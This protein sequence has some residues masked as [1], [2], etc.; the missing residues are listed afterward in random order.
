MNTIRSFVRHVLEEHNVLNRLIIQEGGEGSGGQ[1]LPSGLEQSLGYPVFEVSEEYRSKSAV[2]TTT[3]QKNKSQIISNVEDMFDKIPQPGMN[4]TNEDEFKRA[5]AILKLLNDD[6][7]LMNTPGIEFPYN[8]ALFIIGW[9]NEQQSPLDTLAQISYNA[10][11]IMTKI[12]NIAEK[13]D[14]R[15]RGLSSRSRE[16]LGMPPGDEAVQ[17]PDETIKVPDIET[18]TVGKIIGGV[19]GTG[20]MCLLYKTGVFKL[21]A[22]FV[23]HKAVEYAAKAGVG[24]AK[25]SIPSSALDP[26]VQTALNYMKEPANA[27]SFKSVYTNAIKASEGTPWTVFFRRLDPRI[28]DIPTVAFNTL[29]GSRS[30]IQSK[31]STACTDLWQSTNSFITEKIFNK[32]GGQIGTRKPIAMADIEQTLIPG[33][34]VRLVDVLNFYSK[35]TIDKVE[36]EIVYNMMRSAA[37]TDGIAKKSPDELLEFFKAQTRGGLT[38]ILPASS[39]DA[40]EFAELLDLALKDATGDNLIEHVLGS[41]SA[42]K[43]FDLSPVAKKQFTTLSTESAKYADTLAEI[44]AALFKPMIR[45]TPTLLSGA[46]FFTAGSVL[47]IGLYAIVA[48]SA[49]YLGYETIWGSD[50]RDTVVSED[51]A[52]ILL[53]D[54]HIRASAA[55]SMENIS[56]GG[57]WDADISAKSQLPLNDADDDL[58]K[59]FVSEPKDKVTPARLERTMILYRAAIKT[60]SENYVSELREEGIELKDIDKAVDN[61]EAKRRAKLEKAAREKA[62]EKFKLK[63]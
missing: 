16:A 3:L 28:R 26:A 44:A 57:W 20:A 5:V 45:S 9:E 55:E 18:G 24:A 37:A 40:K 50:N 17:V 13:P 47:Y 34:K 61:F 1:D 51:D 15:A 22:G 35:A 49:A 11:E 54:L 56:S 7:Q 33:V 60:Y 32:I 52:K 38:N 39:S 46:G 58:T 23:Q 27:E 29:L 59:I 21:V 2:L 25:K 43:R 10:G 8:T 48:A 14:S 42:V 53:T 30:E 19:V 31:F 6:R 41:E 62:D 36:N 63:K 12:H 4:I